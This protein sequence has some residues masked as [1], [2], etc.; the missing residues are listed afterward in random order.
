[1]VM[2]QTSCTRDEAV[3]ALRINNNNAINAIMDLMQ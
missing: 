1:M 2:D 3:N